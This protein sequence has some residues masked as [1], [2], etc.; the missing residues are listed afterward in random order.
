MRIV[1]ALGGNA[2]LARGQALTAE[3]Q[4]QN[5]QKAAKSIAAIAK[6]NEIIVIH[7]NG[8]QV[9]MLM[10]QN[11]VYHESSPATTPYPMDVLGAETCGMVGYML[12]QEIKNIDNAL[13]IATIVTQTLIS[14]D[15][16][17]FSNPTK[18]VGPIYSQE[19]ATSIMMKSDKI[20]KADGDKYR[21]VV[22]S[23]QPIDIVELAQVETLLK[24]DNIVIACGGGG[25]PVEFKNN[26]YRGIEC[27]IDKDL[28]A[29]LIAEKLNAEMFIILT[30][31]S[32]YKD[33]GKETQ[34]EM[35]LATPNGLAQFNFPA[36]S[37]GP[38]IDA[39]CKFVNS[40]KGDAAIGSLFELNNIIAHQSGTLITKGEGIQY[41][42]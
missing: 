11:A 12:Q 7:G 13:N 19:E 39:V 33:F 2:L 5:I 8:P 35:K 22:P 32:V 34:Q 25:V 38:K 16:P 30:D 26:K 29:E 20:F 24:A 31:G 37:M 10:E 23:P 15:D 9:G 36:G 1:L 21:R 40:N 3:N 6:D 41:Y 27:V 14:A 4:R 42:K 17:A 28:T 18:F